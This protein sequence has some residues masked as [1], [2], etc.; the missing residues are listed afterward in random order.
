MSRP[1]YA[2]VPTS[3]R[4]AQADAVIVSMH[5]GLH[6]SF[7]DLADYQRIAGHA[8]VD[9]GA[10]LVIGRHT[11]ILKGVEV[12]RGVPIFHSLGTSPSS[13][14]W[15]VAYLRDASA[16]AGLATTFRVDGDEVFP[17]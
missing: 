3:S 2:D 12:Y 13:C 10:D 6:F 1:R 17:E 16:A 11:H 4:R 7:A 14:R 15:S 5:W 9:A 8:A